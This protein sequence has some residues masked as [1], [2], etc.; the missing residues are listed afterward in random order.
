MAMQNRPRTGAPGGPAAR[1]LVVDDEPGML[2]LLRRVLEAEGFRV[3][4]AASAEEADARLAEG[5]FDVVLTDLVMG[6]RGGEHVVR[7]AK[8]DHPETEI[9]VITAYA[10]V[11]S[12]IE[13]MKQG[14]FDYLRKPVLPEEVVHVVRRALEIK[15]LREEVRAL[16]RQRGEGRIHGQILGRSPVMRRIFE[17]VRRAARTDA[18]VLLEGESG[19]GKELFARAIH[20]ESPRSG[21][22][23]VAVNCGAIPAQ[24]LESEIFGHARGAFT[25][26]VQERKGYFEAASGGTLFLDEIGEMAP[27]LQVKLLRT[28]QEGAVTR[29]GETRPRP[30]DVR[31]V[32]A[33]NKNLLEEVRRGAFRSDLYYRL[34]VVHIQIPPL[35]ERR[36]DILLLAHAFL[37]RYSQ[38]YGKRFEEI[39]PRAARM[40]QAYDYPGNVREL[41]NIIECA[42]VIGRGRVLRPSHL[43]EAMD[44]GFLQRM[45]EDG[46]IAEAPFADALARVV[47]AFEKA[48][49]ERMLQRFGGRIHR[50]ALASGLSRRTIERKMRKYHLDRRAFLPGRSR[51]EGEP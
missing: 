19:T 16:R 43:E 6:G 41:E 33:T 17:R 44:A 1:I 11:E 10:S 39:D 15:G 18:T 25:G 34:H 51:A 29:V 32:A 13:V 24:L 28:L 8:R 23:F 22:P 37:R 3:E 20:A 4:C 21:G 9:I 48:Y 12:A 27:H 36:E 30:V 45:E 40:L 5:P 26:A 42:V 31:I 35:R 50:V 14:A 2:D 46:R 7:T 49:L 38:K 47:E